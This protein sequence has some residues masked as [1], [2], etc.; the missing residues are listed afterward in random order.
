MPEKYLHSVEVSEFVGQHGPQFG[1]G[2]DGKQ[3]QT[4]AHYTPRAEPKKAAT[5]RNKRIGSAE[6]ID[7][8]GNLFIQ[9]GGDVRNLLE[10]GWLR[11]TIEQQSRGIKMESGTKAKRQ[12]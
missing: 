11:R 4:D 6:Q 7:F 12:Q 1:D 8:A 3:R 5:V 2:E 9:R 10:E